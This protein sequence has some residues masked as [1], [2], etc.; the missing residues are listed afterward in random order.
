VG[1]ARTAIAKAKASRLKARE[2]RRIERRD[3]RAAAALAAEPLPATLREFLESPEWCGLTLSPMVAAIVDASQGI[4]PTTIDDA[5][6]LRYFGCALDGLPKIARRVLAICAGGRGGKTSRLLAP[7]ALYF[8]LTVPLPTL[9]RREHAVSLILSSE[10][11]F[12]RQALTFAAGYAEGSPKLARLLVGKIATDRF[13]LRRHDGKLV[14]VRVRAAGARGKGGRAFTLCFAAMD[15]A[16]F[17]FD[18]SGVVSDT[19]TYRA[20][21]Q[22][23]VPG[24][25]LWMASTPW[26]DGVG[27]LEEVLAANWGNHD[28]ALAIRGVGTRALNPTWDPTGEIER[29]LRRDDPENAKREIDA[30]P[31]TGGTRHFFSREAIEAV[32]KRDLPQR[33][34]PEAGQTYAAG[35]DTGFTKNSSALTILGTPTAAK[36]GAGR[37]RLALIE[38]RVPKPGSPLQPE[39][40]AE[41]FAG[42]MLPYGLRELVVDGH[43]RERVGKALNAKGASAVAAP[44]KPDAFSKLRTIIHDG[45]LDAPEHPRLRQQLRDVMVKPLPGGGVSI[46]SPQ[47]ADGSHG[48]LVSALANAAA[49]LTAGRSVSAGHVAGI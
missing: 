15:E 4:R 46:T 36:A 18:A 23:I 6:C 43:E 34:A 29:D 31:L 38:E 25:Q 7:A 42:L 33:S 47:R 40:V 17:F 22:R 44:P 35:G 41:E 48:D 27:K 37:V 8:A 45:R 9:R 28:A 32:F 5:T 10:V 26:I 49:R 30:I 13:T 2:V 20:V 21:I 16:C 12:A 24:G 1:I 3:E 14:D 11:A 39:A 19:E